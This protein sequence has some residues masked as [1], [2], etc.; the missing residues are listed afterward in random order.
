MILGGG[1][2]G[3][4]LPGASRRAISPLPAGCCS[5]NVEKSNICEHL[6]LWLLPQPRTFGTVPPKCEI[7]VCSAVPL[8][9]ELQLCKTSLD[10]VQ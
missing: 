3:T 5:Q 4:V 6:F 9:L 7:N 1:D 8:I 2:M 10:F